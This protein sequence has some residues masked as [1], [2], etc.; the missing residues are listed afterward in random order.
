MNRG[1]P[2]TER[3]LKPGGVTREYACSFVYQTVGLMVIRFDMSRGGDVWGPPF[4]IPPG[5]MTLGYFWKRRPFNLYRIHGPGGGVLGHRI[6]ALTDVQF[7]TDSVTYRDLALDWW[8]LPDDTLIEQDRDELEALLASGT[9]SEA[10]G[11]IVEEA[12]RQVY[13][14]YRHIIDDVGVLETRLGLVG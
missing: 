13:S 11:Q 2:V 6:D 1:D 3:K 5:S 12:A 4:S 7:G 10:D 14:R 9:L 8:V